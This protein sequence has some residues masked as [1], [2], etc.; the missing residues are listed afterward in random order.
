MSK[1][2]LVIIFTSICLVSSIGV[3]LAQ[4]LNVGDELAKEFV[5]NAAELIGPDDVVL[6]ANQNHWAFSLT[7][8]L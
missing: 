6:V 5:L 3:R 7:L 4:G 1:T 2:T 8:N